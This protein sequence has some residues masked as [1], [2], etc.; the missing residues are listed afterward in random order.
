TWTWSSRVDE[1]S[2]VPFP[3]WLLIRR[4]QRLVVYVQANVHVKV[5]DYDHDDVN[6]HV[7]DRRGALGCLRSV[8][9][10]VERVRL[11]E[12]PSEIREGL[13][14]FGEHLAGIGDLAEIERKR[15]LLAF[16]RMDG[17]VEPQADV[18]VVKRRYSRLLSRTGP[19]NVDPLAA[20][21]VA[22]QTRAVVDVVVVVDVDFDVDDDVDLVVSR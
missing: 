13:A 21:V 6:D 1:R 5:H 2:A 4:R 10:G 3:I 7:N 14:G 18:A 15:S 22:H 9:A 19:A 17:H 12:E 8:R 11:A 20:R 16:R